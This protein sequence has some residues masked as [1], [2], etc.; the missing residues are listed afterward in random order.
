MFS[1]NDD[2]FRAAP[3]GYPHQVIHI[4]NTQG[5]SEQVSSQLFEPHARAGG[6]GRG[7]GAT[8][9]YLPPASVAPGGGRVAVR[10]AA[11]PPPRAG[12]I[13][14]VRACVR[15]C[16]NDPSAGS[17]TE[18]LLRL[19]LPIESQVWPSSRHPVTAR[20]AGAVPCRAGLQS[21][22]LTKASDW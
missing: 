21:E 11:P 19:L 18:T 6:E 4:S 9:R 2:H 14:H 13:V 20:R 10:H 1:C 3:S 22:G 17:P 15:A 5:T 12:G 16:I 7:A 8:S